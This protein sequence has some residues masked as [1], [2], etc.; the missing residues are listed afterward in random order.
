M[1]SLQEYRQEQLEKLRQLRELGLEAYPAA[2]RR[3]LDLATVRKD[4]DALEGQK[5]W[6]AG[7]LMSLREHGRITFLDLADQRGRLQLIVRGEA[8]EKADRKKGQLRYEDLGLLTRGDFLNAAGE[9]KKSDR[10]E[11]SL[12]VAELR[13]LA[14]VLRPLPLKLEEVRHPPPPPLSGP[15][16]KPA[17]PPAL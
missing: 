17:G 16:Y 11:M 9:L 12:E 1:S 5:K 14:K 7:R 2:S 10:G 15:G 6:L 4:F 8:L 3:D 13:I